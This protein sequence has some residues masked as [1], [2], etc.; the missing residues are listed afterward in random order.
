MSNVEPGNVLDK[1]IIARL[2]QTV[3]ETTAGLENYELDRAARPLVDFVDDFSTWYLRRS[4]E[5]FKEGDKEAEE[6]AA[7]LRFLLLKSAKI[8]AP[9]APF[10]AE[11]IYKT[12]GGEKESVHLENWL[13]ATELSGRDKELLGVMAE[14]RRIASAGLELRAKHSIKV[15]QP[16]SSLKLKTENEKLKTDSELLQILK[17]EL[18][19]KEIIFGAAIE[20]EFA[21]DTEITAELKDEGMIRDLVRELQ[22]LRKQAG[23]VPQD[24]INIFVVGDDTARA[25]ILKYRKEILTAVGG[26][27][28][29]FDA[30][31]DS[32]VR[33]EFALDFG[34]ITLVIG[35]HAS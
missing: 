17:D 33:K 19:V 14:A 32:A 35:V 3:A 12:I 6:A 10:L 11:R 18:N 16:L 28:L 20:D 5:R 26:D 29:V 15:R 34:K 13:E 24:R 1:W 9:F 4:R 2:N 27:D 21:L 22:E 8:F 23:L 25:F 31:P 7:M 30:A